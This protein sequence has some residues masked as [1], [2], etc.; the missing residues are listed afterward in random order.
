VPAFNEA[1]KGR[2]L[3]AIGTAPATSPP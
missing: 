1:M 3:P 2:G